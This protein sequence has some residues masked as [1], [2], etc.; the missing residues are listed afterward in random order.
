MFI[1]II[2]IGLNYNTKSVLSLNNT[3][4]RPIFLVYLR[5]YI[6]FCTEYVQQ[7]YEM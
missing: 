4:I 1:S 5:N 7:Q 2:T 3:N 6:Y